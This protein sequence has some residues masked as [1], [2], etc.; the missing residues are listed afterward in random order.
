VH[1]VSWA[2][3]R[4]DEVSYLYGPY[5][6]ALSKHHHNDAF[7]VGAALR[8]VT[9]PDRAAEVNAAFDR[10]SLDFLQELKA[11]NPSRRRSGTRLHVARRWKTLRAI[12]WT[13]MQH[14]Q[15]YDILSDARLPRSEKKRWTDRADTCTARRARILL[16]TLRSR[17]RSVMHGSAPEP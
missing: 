14:E 11:K 7:R 4:R 10:E 1:L 9:R 12:D 13:H 2:E 17:N 15:T 6:T 16:P 3:E 8:F 5:N